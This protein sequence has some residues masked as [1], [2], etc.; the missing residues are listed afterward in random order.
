MPCKLCQSEEVKIIRKKLRHNIKRDVLRCD[1]CGF[2]F[3][4]D[5]KKSDKKYYTGKEYRKRYGP[6]Y[7][8]E[9]SAEEI[10]NISLPFQG[11]I[12]DEIKD[13]IK[14]SSKVLEVGCAAGYFLHALKD[15]VKTR[16]GLELNKEHAAFIKKKL[17]FKV[18]SKPIENLNITEAPFDLIVSLQVLEHVEN[19]LSFLKAIASNLR[20]NG[21]LYI[22]VPNIDDALLSCY[23]IKGYTDFYFREPHLSYFSAKTLKML[24]DRAGFVGRIYTVQRYTILN[25]MSW[26]LTGKPQKDFS[27]GNSTPSLFESNNVDREIKKD[28]NNFIQQTDLKYKELLKKYNLGENLCFLGKKI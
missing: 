14:P 4:G 24:L 11:A 19:P 15:K 1:K 8:K 6:V 10:F 5:I 25:H 23:K 16:I 22:E 21:Y 2:V 27:V 7:N 26:I 12:K 13:I 28:L 18:Y 20:K 3:L 17:D 9:S